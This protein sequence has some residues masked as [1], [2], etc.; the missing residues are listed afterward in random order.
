MHPFQ[1]DSAE[2]LANAVSQVSSDQNAR[3]LAGGIT[4]VDLMSPV[5]SAHHVW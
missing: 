4:L 1:Y 5:L 3:F 2:S